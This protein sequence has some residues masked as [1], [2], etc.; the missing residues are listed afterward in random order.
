MAN[1]STVFHHTDSVSVTAIA[2]LSLKSELLSHSGLPNG[3]IDVMSSNYTLHNVLCH[4]F[5]LLFAAELAI[6]VNTDQA[7][8]THDLQAISTP[9]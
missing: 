2:V 4:V 8:L 6:A 1:D 3:L 9:V 5:T 7:L